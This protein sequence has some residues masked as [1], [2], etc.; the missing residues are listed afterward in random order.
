MGS[1]LPKLPSRDDDD[2]DD[3]DTDAKESTV[4]ILGA[5]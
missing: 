1:C 4:C 2:D 3:D 5:V